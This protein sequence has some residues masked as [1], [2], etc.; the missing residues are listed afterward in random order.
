MVRSR[1]AA[2]ASARSARCRASSSSRRNRAVSSATSVGGAV[3]P[4]GGV[5]AASIPAATSEGIG[6]LQ[7]AVTVLVCAF[8]PA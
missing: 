4:V 1:S 6:M 2:I 7:L 3:S 5:T 8:D